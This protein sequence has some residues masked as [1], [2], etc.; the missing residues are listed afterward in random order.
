MSSRQSLHQQYASCPQLLLTFL[1]P[2]LTTKRPTGPTQPRMADVESFLQPLATRSSQ[3]EWSQCTNCMHDQQH[4]HSH[5]IYT[6]RA[7]PQRCG[8]PME[9]VSPEVSRAT[10]SGARTGTGSAC[11]A[12]MIPH[13]LNA[14]YASSATG[15]PTLSPA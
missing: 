4:N 10:I 15:L 6:H 11:L 3:P 2:Y 12:R 7:G 14:P 9:A 5:G 13:S 8:A 1:G